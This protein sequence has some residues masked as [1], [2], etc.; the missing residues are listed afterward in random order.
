[1]RTRAQG[2]AADGRRAG[3]VRSRAAGW[4]SRSGAHGARVP[5]MGTSLSRLLTVLSLLS[6]RWLELGQCPGLPDGPRRQGERGGALGHRGWQRPEVPPRGGQLGEGVN[7]LYRC[8]SLFILT[9]NIL[10]WNLLSI[11]KLIKR[12]S[13]ACPPPQPPTYLFPSLNSCQF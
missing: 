7:S 13:P 6:G 9:F 2:P 11:K 8:I 12:A 3:R 5:G 1:M 10:F 4:C